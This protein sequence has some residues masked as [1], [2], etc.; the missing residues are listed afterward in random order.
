MTSSIAD[1]DLDCAATGLYLYPI[2]AC[3]AMPVREL[4]LDARGGAAGDRGW[5]IVDADGAVTWQGAHARL[6]LVRP[7]VAGEAL[8]LHSAGIDPVTAPPVADLAP[9]RV[10]I[11][12]ERTVRHDEFDAADAGDTVAGWL[13]RVVG[14]PLRLVRLGEAALA[15]EGTNA[16]HLVFSASVAAVDGQLAAAGLA[17]ADPLRYR[18]NILLS[19]PAGEA[20]IEFIEDSLAA[21]DWGTGTAATRLDITAPCVRCVD[22]ASARVDEAVLDTLA[23]LSQQRQ[24]GGPTV[25]GVYARGAAGARLRVGDAARMV[26]AF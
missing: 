22:P 18:P 23:R 25:F 1:L 4:A 19:A 16:L 11:W 5:A 15:R 12:N 17:A 21:L 20:A 8:S 24:P 10:K 26:L 7:H 9:C 2:K 14:A 3:A 6:A 13:A